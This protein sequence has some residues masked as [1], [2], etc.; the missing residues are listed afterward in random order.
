MSNDIVKQEA[1]TPMI[2]SWNELMDR[3]KFFANSQL[4][5]ASIRGKPAD[6]A[7]VLQIGWE[8]GIGP[9][10]A[11]NGVDVIQGRP[12]ISP[13]L[14]LALARSKIPNF[15]VE[16]V[17]MTESKAIVKMARDRTRLEESY[18]A[19]WDDQKAKAM[20]LLTKD[21][22]QK[23]RGNMYKWRAV[24]EA[25][26]VVAPDI[27]KGLYSPDEVED[28]P[29]EGNTPHTPPATDKA[30][31]LQALVNKPEKPEPIEFKAEV[32]NAPM[33]AEVIQAQPGGMEAPPF[34]PLLD[35][36]VKAEG[37]LKGKKLGECTEDD[38]KF[39]VGTI[40]AKAKASG[41]QP[42]GA[43]LEAV[44]RINE[45]LGKVNEQQASFDEFQAEALG[46]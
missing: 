15:Y 1:S 19:R 8:L 43:M 23:Q 4:V 44:L 7:I 26:R 32:V 13:Q 16:F 38:L 30:R 25:L 24:M 31:R 28:I 5:P 41:K 18:T 22:Y 36:V 35:Y 42:Q 6:V 2:S 39:Y 27:L 20:G 45:Y 3:A 37:P 34:D 33:K 29:P 40:E 14:G 21:N 10:Q 46:K 17:E 9:M 11:L 12:A